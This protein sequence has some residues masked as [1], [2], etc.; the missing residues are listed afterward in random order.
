[1]SEKQSEQQNPLGKIIAKALQDEAFK[2]QLMADPGAVLKAE[3]IDIPEGITVQVVADSESV[4]H[5]VLPT[6]GKRELTEAE[7]D[8]VAGGTSY[9]GCAQLCW[10]ERWDNWCA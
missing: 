10:D 8:M 7:L 9:I 1:M 4:W 5:L 3:G 2:H 6:T